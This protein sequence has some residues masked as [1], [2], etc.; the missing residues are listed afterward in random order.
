MTGHF[1]TR[2]LDTDGTFISQLDRYNSAADLS[3][4]GSQMPKLVG[5]AYASKLYRQM[6]HL[7]AQAARFSNCGN[8]IVFGT[9]GNAGCAEG[10]FREAVNAVGVRQV[11]MLTQEAEHRGQT[12]RP[13]REQPVDAEGEYRRSTSRGVPPEKARPGDGVRRG[14]REMPRACR[15]RRRP[16]RRSRAGPW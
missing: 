3:P 2:L 7:K 12:I 14:V 4:I 10:V 9:I 15:R 16:L 11:P 6:D 5:L 13:C 1:A 8:E